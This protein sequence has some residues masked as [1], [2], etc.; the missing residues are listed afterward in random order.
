MAVE[1]LFLR[2]VFSTYGTEW[3]SEDF[4]KNKTVNE[5]NTLFLVEECDS[6]NGVFQY[7]RDLLTGLQ[8]RIAPERVHRN[9]DVRY[10]PHT[11]HDDV[12]CVF[13]PERVRSE[14]PVFLDG[15][16]IIVGESVT[17]PN[18]YP[19]AETH[20]V[21]VITEAHDPAEIT[22]TQIEDA[23]CGQIAA[24]SG[25]DGYAS[26]N[27]NYLPSSGASMLHPHMQGMADTFP[28]FHAGV[29]IER[30]EAFSRREGRVYRECL[31]E[32][33]MDSSRYLFGDELPF[34]AHA[35][36]LGEKEVRAYLPV[37]CA[38]ELEPWCGILAEGIERVISLY[39]GAGH[40]AFNMSLFFDAAGRPDKGFRA[41]CSLIARINPSA[42]AMSDS[43]FMERMHFEP[44]VMTLPEDLAGFLP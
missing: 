40:Y 36:P 20:V 24:L 44:I 26:C 43:A 13:C 14:T 28:T 23:L 4:R 29:V 5:M 33:E 27:W 1:P 9:I 39:R 22:A 2:D 16:R 34:F 38:G 12:P 19:F 15:S 10:R 21:T 18:L 32:Q 8:C 30:S 3:L 42:A 17:F 37:R 41:F 7:R 25:C 6:E 31:I 11:F 35:V